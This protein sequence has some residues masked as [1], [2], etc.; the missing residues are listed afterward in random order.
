M[1]KHS[2]EYLSESG[3]LNS[4]FFAMAHQF[5]RESALVDPGEMSDLKR[6]QEGNMRNFAEI[7]GNEPDVPIRSHPIIPIETPEINWSR[8]AA[9]SAFA[10]KIEVNVKVTER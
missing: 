4:L 1:L 10:A 7:I 3:R 9:K 8:I 6:C 5:A 2:G